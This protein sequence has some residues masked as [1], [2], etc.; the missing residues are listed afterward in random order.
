MD[1]LESF[2]KI[3]GNLKKWATDPIA[4]HL[5][6]FLIWALFVVGI[7][8]IFFSR[9]H[10]S[11]TGLP[12][13]FFEYAD[14]LREP[15]LDFLSSIPWR[16]FILLPGYYFYHSLPVPE[17]EIQKLL[18]VS[19]LTALAYFFLFMLLNMHII[20]VIWAYAALL[21]FREFD[22]WLNNLLKGSLPKWQNESS[23][24]ISETG[25][26]IIVSTWLFGVLFL[27]SICLYQSFRNNDSTIAF[28][29]N[30]VCES[31]K[32]VRLDL[33]DKDFFSGW[34]IFKNSDFVSIKRKTP[35]GL[36]GIYESV[37]VSIS[38]IKNVVYFPKYR[39]SKERSDAFTACSDI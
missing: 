13:G 6:S 29:K 1:F 19:I 18:V 20:S 33:K 9:V 26:R 21:L 34:L 27:S 38:E 25:S 28:V 35:N 14:R 30:R 24:S 39:N 7:Y 23:P 31:F 37:D 2:P 4:K 36:S 16:Y 32:M 10:R 3:Q 12:F 11:V 8:T 22:V 15:Q 17:K 5:I